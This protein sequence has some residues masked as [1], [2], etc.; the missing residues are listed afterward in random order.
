MPSP[1]SHAYIHAGGRS[2]SSLSAEAIPAFGSAIVRDDFSPLKKLIAPASI[3]QFG[4]VRYAAIAILALLAPLI[5]PGVLRSSPSQA[6][7]WGLE[8]DMGKDSR[9]VAQ[10]FLASVAYPKC[11][12][13]AV[14]C[15]DDHARLCGTIVRC[16]CDPTERHARYVDDTAAIRLP[17]PRNEPPTGE[18]RGS[19]TALEYTLKSRRVTALDRSVGGGAIRLAHYREQLIWRGTLLK[20]EPRHSVTE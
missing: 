1:S 8:P 4:S 12:A 5:V 11:Q 14:M 9:V 3:L 20:D 15:R 7:T 17:R 19:Q 10:H 13:L 2:I 16:P 6:G 18:K